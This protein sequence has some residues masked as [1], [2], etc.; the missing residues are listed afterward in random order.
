VNNDRVSLIN[1]ED[2]MRESYLSYAMSVIASRALPDVRDGLKPVQRRILYAMRDMGMTPDKQHRKSAG[3]IG[4]VLK[5]YHPHGDSSVYDA[6]VRMAQDFTLRYPLIDGHGNFGSIDP[7][8]PAAYR[9]TEARLGR[10]AMDMLVDIDKET[11]DFVPNFDNQ[12]T[13]P[14]VLPA[15]LPQLLINGSSGIAVGMATNI[16]P[17]NIGEICDAIVKVIDYSAAGAAET[18]DASPEEAGADGLAGPD[19]ALW[20]ELLDIVKGPDFPTGGILM[21]REAIRTAYLTGRGSVPLRGRAEIIEEDGKTKI[22]ITEVP[23]QVSVNRILEAISDAHEEKRILGI[24]RLDNESNRHGMRIVVQLSRSATPNVVLNQLYKQTPLQSSFAFN[25]LALVPAMRSDGSA[26][27]LAGSTQTQLEPKVLSLLDILRYFIE[28]RKE[29]VTRRT[30]YELSRARTRAHLLLGFLVA[31]DNIDR[32]ITIIR[33]S[34]TVDTAR[35]HLI[36]EPFA[37]SDA[38]RR[39]ARTAIDDNFR[40]SAEQAA[41]IV[42]M[43][44]RTLV[45]LERQKIEDEHSELVTLIAQLE[46]LLASEKMILEV[47]KTETLDVRKRFGD[48]RKTPV[49]ALEGELSIEDI[50]ADTDVVITSTVGGYIKRVS[51]DT[52]RQQNRGGRGVVGIANLKKEDVVANFFV[53]TTHQ[54]VLF[55]TNKGR[56]YRLRAYEIPDSTRQSRGTAL[57]NL[58][59]LPPGESVTAVFPITDF[60][61]DNYLVMVTRQGVIKKTK[62][63]EFSNVR[64]NGLNAIGLDDND[65]LLGVDLSNGSRD[66]ILA[67]HDGMAV[68]FTETDVRPMGRNARG[69]RAITLAPGDTVVAMDVVEDD[70]REVL[71]VTSQAYGKRTPIDDYR[72][73]SRGG[74]GVKA[75]AKEKEIGYVIDQ[76]LVR[77][78][79]ELLL[80]TSGNQVI[81]IPVD[82]IRRAGRST[83]GVRLQRLAEGDEVIAIANLGQVSKRVADITGEEPVTPA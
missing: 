43:R 81:R 3:V 14:V 33:E 54:H 20:R 67:T 61:G 69:V 38:F 49:E 13:E 19:A 58:L 77:S 10:P 57:V 34:D 15:R 12:G 2:E 41:A 62:L 64:R 71:I 7:D 56:A 4:E 42:D 74:K 46:E 29:V 50:I 25:M 11:V 73:T 32:V 37:L 21:G 27:V 17:H 28:H 53:A 22:L 66:I 76:I 26:Y 16:P 8:P 24:S 83:K 23:F 82:Q 30:R 51:V 1:V 47:V 52:F 18:V 39:M 6:L 5:N 45:G 55:F 31:L 40:L 68:H 9:Y 35:E 59:T 70:R 80:I 75:F 60:D 78:D 48:A 79:D 63:E 36:A 44:L 72:H 65:E